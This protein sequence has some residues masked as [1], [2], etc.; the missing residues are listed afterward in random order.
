[1]SEPLAAVKVAPP[2]PIEMAAPVAWVMLPAS[3]VTESVLACVAAWLTA[4]RISPL[5]SVMAM[6][7]EPLFR[8]FTA[9]VKSLPV[10]VS[11][12]AAPPVSKVASPAPGAC[13]IAAAWVIAPVV[14][15]VS[16][17]VP[18]FNVPSDVEP[19]SL[20]NTSPLPLVVTLITPLK[21]FA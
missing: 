6:F 12:I 8:R 15:T 16:G 20:M 4:P 21:A 10:F 2:V 9:P 13:T 19:P 11:V 14:T 3:T 17:P 1:M 7:F 18:R 5:E